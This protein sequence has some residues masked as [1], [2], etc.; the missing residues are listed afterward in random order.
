MSAVCL[1]ASPVPARTV[2]E[3]SQAL[4]ASLGTRLEGDHYV[5]N[6]ASPGPVDP[7]S[8]GYVPGSQLVLTARRPG[9]SRI[10]AQAICT[11]NDNGVVSITP[12]P[13]HFDAGLA[14]L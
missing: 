4:A 12:Q 2:H 9:D 1:A 13:L 3:C 6:A 14:G 11:Y 5:R 8:V 7:L 10:V